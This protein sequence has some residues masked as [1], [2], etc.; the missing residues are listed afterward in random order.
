MSAAVVIGLTLG[1]GSGTGAV[2]SEGEVGPAPGSR[3]TALPAVSC[4]DCGQLILSPLPRV[5]DGCVKPHVTV[6]HKYAKYAGGVRTKVN[7]ASALC[8]HWG[9]S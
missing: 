2:E 4:A 8:S 1:N 6:L 9:R 5:G 7:A 3:L